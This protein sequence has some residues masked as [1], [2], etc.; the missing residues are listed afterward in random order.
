MNELYRLTNRLIEA[1]VSREQFLSLVTDKVM[2]GAT[3]RVT[4][5]VSENAEPLHES[6]VYVVLVERDLNCSLKSIPVELSSQRVLELPGI[7][8]WVD[9]ISGAKIKPFD[10]TYDFIG[11]RHGVRVYG[12]RR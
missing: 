1:G 8:D 12:G 3:E 6:H 9:A 4:R 10:K 11:A 5:W 7:P 2:L